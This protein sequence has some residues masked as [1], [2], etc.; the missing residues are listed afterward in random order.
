MKKILAI[1]NSFS[2]DA[3]RYI[4]AM[5][6]GELLVRNCYIGGCSLQRHWNNVVVDAAEYDYE[7]DAVALEKIALSDALTRE[8]WDYITVQ[9]VSSQSGFYDSYEPFMRDLLAYVK[10]TCPKAKIVFHRTWPYEDNSQHGSFPLYGCD[11]TAMY[12]AIVRAT[13]RVATH[14]GLPIIDCG[15][16][17]YKG[18]KL[19]EFNVADGGVSL[20]RDD[21]H[22]G[23]D[24]GRYLAGLCWYRFFMGKSAETVTFA[25]ENTDPQKIAALKAL[26]G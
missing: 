17:V 13:D 3:T 19:P 4:E 5:A 2:Q 6:E 14:Y 1:G 18:A 21:H 16:A 26:V 22:L 11:R 12:E 24:Y 7:K 25:P 8:K 23:Y 10:E 9:Q 20:Y 15:T